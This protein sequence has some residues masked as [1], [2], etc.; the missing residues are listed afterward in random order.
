M[1]H[2]EHRSATMNQLHSYPTLIHTPYSIV[3]VQ[4]SV[5]RVYLSMSVCLFASFGL[6][7]NSLGWH[8]SLS[9]SLSLSL[10]LSLSHPQ[11]WPSLTKEV[12]PLRQAGKSN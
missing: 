9:I 5:R 3:L 1:V 4:Y 11:T 6:L 8:G 12:I 2:Y 7:M 10:S